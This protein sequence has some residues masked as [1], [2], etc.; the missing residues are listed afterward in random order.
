MGPSPGTFRRARH[1]ADRR[2]GRHQ[3]HHQEGGRR[4]H[5][6]GRPEGTEKEVKASKRATS[7]HGNF[8]STP[9]STK[10]KQHQPT[11]PPQPFLLGSL[12][13]HKLNTIVLYGV[14]RSYFHR[15]EFRRIEP[16]RMLPCSFR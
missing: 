4:N 1:E 9:H 16:S 10:L 2:C 6:Q 3:E 11:A 13:T 14:V 8:E 5:D 15:K 12:S 7:P